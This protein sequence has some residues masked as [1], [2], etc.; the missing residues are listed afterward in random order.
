MDIFDKT[1]EKFGLTS[2]IVKVK[3]KVCIY[4]YESNGGEWDRLCGDIDKLDKMKIVIIKRI[5]ENKIQG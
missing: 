1:M 2:N 3:N 5:Y 4:V